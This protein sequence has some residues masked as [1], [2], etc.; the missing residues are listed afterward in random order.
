VS[1]RPAAEAAYD[2]SEIAVVGMSGRFPGAPDLDVLWRNLAQGVESIAA[3]SHEELVA[4]GEDPKKL[5]DPGYVRSRP[6]LDGVELFDAA[7]FGFSPRE[8]EV[9]DPQLRLFLECAWTAL[10]HAGHDTERFKGR[11]SLF[12]GAGFSNYLV[13]NLYKNRPVMDAF[14]DQQA[15]I[16]NVQDSLVTM[17][18]YKLNLKGIC[19]AVQTFCSTSLVGV[20]LACQNL[21]SFESDLALAGGVNIYVPQERGYIYEEGSILSRDGHCR[22]FDARADGT[23]FGNGLGIVVLRRLE[24]ALK[25][26]D[27]VHA[28]IRGSAVNNDGSLKVSFAAPGVVGQTEVVVEALSAA[29]VDP[30]TIGY[31]E[32]HGTGTRLG[33]PAELSALTK[34]FRTGTDRRG[35]CALGSVKSNL[36]H[37]DAAA[38]VTGLIKVILSLHHE[39]IPPSLHFETPNPVIDFASTP[40]YVN[41]ALKEWPRGALPRRAG[42]SAFGVGGTNAHVIVE[43]APVAAR[44][45]TARS[46]QLL[47]LSAR[48]AGALDAAAQAL[49]AH[50]EAHPGLELAD[51][52]HTLQLGRRAFAERRIV[53]AAS[54]AEV[55]TALRSATPIAAVCQRRSP[56]VIARFGPEQAEPVNLF[57]EL[58]ELA[59]AFRDAL[60]QCAAAAGAQGRPMLEALYPAAGCYEAAARAMRE[61]GLAP[62]ATFAVEFALA[63]LW[64]SWGVRFESRIGEGVGALVAACLDGT[65]DLPSAVRQALRHGRSDAA[66]EAPPPPE[67]TDAAAVWQG[68]PADPDRLCLELCVG[69]VAVRSV[70]AWTRGAA[71]ALQP[72]ATAYAQVLGT[73]G[74]LWLAGVEVEWPALHAPER[75]RRVPLPTYHFEREPFWVEPVDD[76]PPPEERKPAEWLYHP[77]WKSALPAAG[78]AAGRGESVLVFV[79]PGGVGLRI[80]EHLRASGSEVVTVRVGPG[81]AGDPA[82][83]YTLDPREAGHYASLWADLRRREAAPPR[84]IHLWG[85]EPLDEAA[86][87]RERFE[88]ASDLGF[89]SLLHLVAARPEGPLAV[90]VVAAGLHQIAGGES[91]APEKAPLIPLCRVLVQE[92]HDLNCELIDVETADDA[93]GLVE[94]LLAE[95]ASPEAEPVVAYRRGRRWIQDFERVPPAVQERSSPRV[96][97]G[98]VTFITGGL[99]DVGFVL[100]LYLAHQP[101]A[102]L[103]LTGRSGLPPR[104]GWAEWLGTHADETCVRIKKVQALE[105]LGAE[106]LVLKADASNASEMHAA[107]L[108]ARDRFGALTGVI[109][110]AGDLTPD[111]FRP[112]EALGREACERQFAPKVHGLL[113]LDEALRGETLDF[114]VLTS[115]LSSVLGGLGYA[116]YAGANA[117]M[118]A[119]AAR[120]HQ[121]GERAWVSV[122]WDQWE[123]AGRT[124]SGAARQANRDGVTLK[125]EEGVAVFERVLRLRGVDRVVVSRAPLG[126]RLER[127][128]RL[129]AIEPASGPGPV[130]ASAAGA[131]R[132]R[133]PL[134]TAYVA[135]GNEQEKIL[136]GIWQELLGI[137]KVGIHDNF[138]E[139]G[140]HSLFA[141]R[142]LSR[143]R[144]ALRVS[145]PLEAV[146]E[147]PTIAELAGRVAAVAWSEP[148]SESTETTGER[149]E[150]EI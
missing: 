33:D 114:C 94:A 31:V 14:G 30:D 36:G 43:E 81:F 61:Q 136:A 104:E 70:K 83:G 53:V 44:L 88:R 103:V 133:P 16:Y 102:K 22:A 18:G 126:E 127:W 27:T 140:G 145:L 77:V 125:P 119:F 84:V 39:R 15:T 131:A 78:S 87:G 12:A 137:E 115:S 47:V 55:V 110:A 56:P 113:A 11:I 74:Q 122:D 29:G 148:S 111:T 41:A 121:K 135:P 108:A 62:L 59:P 147:A 35:F 123:F 25:E 142:L 134:S 72:S 5:E 32:A 76:A 63:R 99:G 21:L 52:A 90:K 45:P 80:A 23:V 105:A 54:L 58:N 150:I 92:H 49:A 51:V 100:G 98:G 138:F 116:A 10:E 1:E 107:V 120:Q 101:K 20:H 85:L 46:H 3:F 91:L 73:L 117:F 75:R 141:A 143:V 34:A 7:F 6:I 9:L 67:A 28:V 144:S 89:Y 65:T 40:F 106:V 132:P 64:E 130:G 26:G 139:L 109:H 86:S 129:S 82:S 13:H 42:V 24:D 69:S 96:R 93:G 112:V 4:A 71:T 128:V 66:P 95:L 149:V 68:L 50:L 48:T 17:V 38:G 124:P 57:R 2:G 97:E 60:R 37:L 19:C 8:A 146:F 118:D 79:D